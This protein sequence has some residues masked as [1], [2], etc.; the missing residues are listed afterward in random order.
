[1]RATTSH[2]IQATTR[3]AVQR[4]PLCGSRSPAPSPFAARALRAPRSAPVPRFC[5]RAV[6]PPKRPVS[7]VRAA[8]RSAGDSVSE[9]HSTPIVHVAALVSRRLEER[10]AGAHRVRA[11]LRA[12]DVQGLEE[13]RARGGITSLHRQRRRPEQ[14]LHRPKTRRSSGRRCRR[15]TCRW[16]SGSKPIAWRRCGSTR[17]AFTTRAR[18][19]QGRAPDAR[20]EPAVRAAERDHLRP[21][22]HGRTRTSTRRSAAWPTSRRRRSTDVREFY[23]DLLR[24]GERDA[25][26][27]SAT[28]TPAQATELVDAVSRP[29]AEGR[30]SRCRATS[31]R[32]RR[33]RRSGA[34]SSR[35]R[36]RC[37]PSSSR[38]HITYDG[39]PDSYPLHIT[40]KVLSDGQSAAHLRASSSTTSSSRSRPSAAATSSRIR[41]CSTRWRSCSPGRRREDGEQALIAE[42]DQAEA[43]SRSRP[44]ELQRAKNQ[45]ARDYILGRESNQD[46]ALHLAHARRDPQRHH[47]GRRRVRYLHERDR[48]RGAYR[49]RGEGPTST[50]ATGCAARAAEGERGRDE[51][52]TGL[53]RASCVLAHWP[54]RQSAVAP[55]SAL[56]A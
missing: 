49:A 17:T 2:Q 9:D 18:G 45:F 52:R 46:K 47:H 14:R 48:Q 54:A 44:H 40:S 51:T 4:R 13:R 23:R 38:Y 53:P 30:P 32:S 50:R 29:R 15:S 25:G 7:D 6:R 34:S 28:S 36:G 26:A 35:R 5:M 42:L 24:A 10:A 43:A 31:R 27:S 39:H 11:P 33:R 1:M 22:V 41:T 8:Q 56:A 37:R 12:H 55:E 20:R 16:C 21:G 19:G 3:I